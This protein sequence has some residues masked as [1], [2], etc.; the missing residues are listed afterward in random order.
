[1]IKGRIVPILCRMDNE[2]ALLKLN[3]KQISEMLKYT[4]QFLQE[5][6]MFPFA[7]LPIPCRAGG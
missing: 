3:T 2:M 7:L 6:I 5:Y 1:M 4:P